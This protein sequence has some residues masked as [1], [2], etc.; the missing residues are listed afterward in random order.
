MP[1]SSAYQQMEEAIRLWAHLQTD[2]SFVLV[3]G[4]RARS[5]PPPDDWSD[6][7]LIVY[8][9]SPERYTSDSGWLDNFGP[10]W[11]ANLGQTG[12]GDP[13]WQ[14]IYEGGLKVDFVLAYS[15]DTGDAQALPR[16]INESPY[17]FVF[18]RGLRVLFDRQGS[19]EPVREA[20]RLAPAWTAPSEKEFNANIQSLFLSAM[21]TARLLKRG[22]LWQAHQHFNCSLKDLLI[23]MLEWHARSIHRPEK[24]TWYSGRY[25]SEWAD[26]RAVAAIP[27]TSAPYDESDQWR[28]LISS[29]ELYRWLAREVAMALAYTY[30]E[31]LDRQLSGWIRSVQPN[32]QG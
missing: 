25:L 24:D 18:Q 20:F 2:V 32:E 3:V 13:E 5:E 15:P 17:R 12:C 10:V 23:S 27:A 7:D 6:L 11:M 19:V 30:P 16:L 4:S 31:H 29:L 26:P 14:V 8:T 1:I 21:R 9:E 28:A 22:E